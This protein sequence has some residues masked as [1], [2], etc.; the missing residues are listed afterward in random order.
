M[1]GVGVREGRMGEGDVV[2]GVVERSNFLCAISSVLVAII[3]H[4]RDQYFCII[5]L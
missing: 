2:V 5:K 1:E 4:A 3:F